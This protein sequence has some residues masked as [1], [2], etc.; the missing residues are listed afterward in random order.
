MTLHEQAFMVYLI[1][2]NYRRRMV[3]FC[4]NLIT[5][6]IPVIVLYWLKLSGPREFG[7]MLVTI[8]FF[9]RVIYIYFA[10][11][12]YHDN[13]PWSIKKRQNKLLIANKKSDFEE[14]RFCV[15]LREYFYV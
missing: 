13:L 4:F 10:D 1:K 11:D 14:L 15:P 12:E 9:I 6:L 5:I 3:Y 8:M 2:R 7:V